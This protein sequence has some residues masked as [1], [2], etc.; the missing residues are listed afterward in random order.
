VA[1][2]DAMSLATTSNDRP[3][4]RTVLLKSFDTAGFVFYTNYESRKGR[5]LAHNPRAALSFAWLEIHRQ[6]RIEGTA[7]RL[8]PDESDAY[9]ATRP[10]G[11]QLAAGISRQSEVISEGGL[12][13]SAFAAAAEKFQGGEIPRPEHWGGFRLQPEEFEFWQGRPDRLHDRIRYRWEDSTWVKERL[14]P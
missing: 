6:V 14:S 7:E 12:L 5:E 2:P 4:V 3:S 11:A 8:T 1:Q 9:Y 13:E 10:R